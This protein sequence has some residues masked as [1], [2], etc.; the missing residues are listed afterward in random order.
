MQSMVG[1]L[2]WLSMSTRPDIV[3]VTNLL[4]KHVRQP[5]KGHLEAVKRVLRYLK[6]TA[7]KG[8]TFTS[9]TQSHLEAFVKFPIPPNQ[10]TALTDA[11][12][13][14]KIKVTH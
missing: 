12:W 7:N 4:A 3:T 6:G 10:L 14:L 8:I 1:S 9:S 11:N 13:G 2:T 5:S